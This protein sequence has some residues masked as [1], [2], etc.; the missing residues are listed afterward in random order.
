MKERKEDYIK[1]AKQILEL[2]Y[3]GRKF[4]ISKYFTADVECIAPGFYGRGEK[5]AVYLTALQKEQYTIIHK[6]YRLVRDTEQFAVVRARCSLRKKEQKEETGEKEDRDITMM[7]IRSA[8]GIGLQY[9]HISEDASAECFWVKDIRERMYQLREADIVYVEAIHNH[10]VWH[11][12]GYA[13]E[14]VKLLKEVEESLSDNFVRI[15]R[16]YIVNRR[17]VQM[18][19]RCY[20]RLDNG[21]VLQIPVKKYCEVK[22]MLE[23]NGQALH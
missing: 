9:I 2:F 19:D 16:S 5:L 10:V 6:S 8:Q 22:K 21:D 3:R 17:H 18:V 20:A 13:I 1:T 7:L 14:T 15:H 12:Q 11:C 4:L 23:K